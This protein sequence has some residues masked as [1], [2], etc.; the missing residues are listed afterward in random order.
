MAFLYDVSTGVGNRGAG[1]ENAK[2]GA[3]VFRRIK[4]IFEE[5]VDQN[6]ADDT[7]EDLRDDIAGNA[8]PSRTCRRLPAR[9]SAQG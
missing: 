5:D 3:G 9:W 4:V 7:A 1:G 6:A 8:A 2:L